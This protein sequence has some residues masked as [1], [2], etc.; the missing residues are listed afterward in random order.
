M[1]TGQATWDMDQTSEYL[2]RRITIIRKVWRRSIS[3][4]ELKSMVHRKLLRSM[5][6]L[7]FLSSLRF[8]KKFLLICP[9]S[10]SSYWISTEIYS[11]ITESCQ[12]IIRLEFSFHSSEGEGIEIHQQKQPKSWSH[13]EEKWIKLTWTPCIRLCQKKQV[14]TKCEKWGRSLA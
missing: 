7:R 6:L 1:K 11:Q 2:S 12:V 9:N 14:Q 13:S 4:W 5:M 10:R 8:T 3:K